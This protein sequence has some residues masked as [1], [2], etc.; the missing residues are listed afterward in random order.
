[1]RCPSRL[2]DTGGTALMAISSSRWSTCW[3]DMERN[4]IAADLAGL[5][6][7]EADFAG[8]MAAAQADAHAAID[9]EQINL[10]SPEAVAGRPFDKLGM[11]K[12]KR[13]KTGYTTDADALATS[14][15]RP[16]TFLEAPLRHRDAMRLRVTVEG[17]IRSVADAH[18]RP[19]S[20]PSRRRAAPS[21]DPNLQNVP[22]RTEE[23]PAIREAF[24][25]GDGLSR[26]AARDYSQIEMRIMAHLSGTRADRGLPDGERPAPSGRG[27]SA[28][29]RPTAA[30]RSKVKAMSYGLAYGCRPSA[31]PS[32]GYLSTGEAR[33][34]D[35]RVVLRPLRRGPRLPARCRRR[36]RKPGGTPG[37]CSGG[38][39]TCPT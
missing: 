2:D 33:G 19:V 32:S 9:G 25:V 3:W 28:S 23:G 38:A 17:L 15:P 39:A 21:T 36:R 16:S 22:I 29:T 20:R 37:R 6:S 18:P 7:L 12:T 34:L 27:C 10:G 35:G 13:T 11:P 24:V 30:M 4:G 1:M 5:T 8:K 14:S 31:C 26:L